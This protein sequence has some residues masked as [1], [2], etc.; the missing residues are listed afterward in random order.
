MD[1]L[2]NESL[3]APLPKPIKKDYNKILRNQLIPLMKHFREEENSDF[4]EWYDV[5]DTNEFYKN[6]MSIKSRSKKFILLKKCMKENTIYHKH[7]DFYE[8]NGGNDL[9]ELLLDI[10]H[11]N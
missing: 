9:R 4:D 1:S 11:A 7:Y 10:I 5:I 2:W 8:I 3:L 6:I